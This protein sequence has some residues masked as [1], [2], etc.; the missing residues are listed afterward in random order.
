MDKDRFGKDDELSTL[1]IGSENCTYGQKKV[2]SAGLEH[3]NKVMATPRV[4]IKEWHQL[5][6]PDSS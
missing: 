6:T 3:W 4:E 1:L 5:S 2:S